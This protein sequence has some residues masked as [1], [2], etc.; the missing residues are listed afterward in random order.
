MADVKKGD[1]KYGDYLE[2]LALH[3]QVMRLAM[4]AKQNTDEK[5]AE[6]LLH[7]VEHLEAYY[8]KK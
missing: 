1:P 5:I 6:D 3:H 8:G 2:A 4:K 7:A